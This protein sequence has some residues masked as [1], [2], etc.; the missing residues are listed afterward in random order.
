MRW[1][2]IIN[3]YAEYTKLNGVH[4]EFWAFILIFFEFWAFNF[5]LYNTIFTMSYVES[6]CNSYSI[7]ISGMAQNKN[8]QQHCDLLNHIKL[9]FLNVKYFQRGLFGEGHIK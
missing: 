6:L 9:I 5:W 3:F 1:L 4:T 8:K 7:P 2:D